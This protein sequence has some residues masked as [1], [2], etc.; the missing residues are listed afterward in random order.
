[1]FFK[2]LNNVVFEVDSSD[3]EL[4]ESCKSRFIECDSNGNEIVK[5]KP[6]SEPKKKSMFSKKKAKKD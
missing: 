2:K 1:M 3:K 5:E 4:V 6:K